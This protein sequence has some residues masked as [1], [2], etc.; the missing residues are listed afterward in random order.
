MVCVW[1]EGMASAIPAPDE[2]GAHLHSPEIESVA[3]ERKASGDRH[4]V[5]AFD[6]DLREFD[7]A[8]L[9]HRLHVERA[10][11]VLMLQNG[12]K[13]KAVQLKDGH[14]DSVK[15]NLLE[16][17]LGHML[18]RQGAITEDQMRK[19]IAQA[20]KQGGLQGEILIAM[21][22]IDE[23]RLAEALRAQAI[24][25]LYEIFTWKRGRFAF[26][27][28]KRIKGGNTLA[29]DYSVANM[30]LAGCRD[31]VPG[32]RIAEFF[33][34]YGDVSMGRASNEFER[35]QDVTVSQAEEKVICE[36]ANGVLVSAYA[37]AAEPIRRAVYGLVATGL[38]DTMGEPAPPPRARAAEDDD[39]LSDTMPE[40]VAPAPPAADVDA[41]AK[42]IAAWLDGARDGTHYE[43][44]D[45][46]STAGDEGI[47]EAYE[48][49]ARR[50]HRDRFHG[51]SAAVQ[52]IADQAAAL[53]ARA[54][55][56]VATADKRLA[57]AQEAKREAEED[58]DR[59][60]TKRLLKAEAAFQR[61]ETA[62]RTR[63]YEAALG[64]FGAAVEAYPEE[65][66]Y[67][68]HYG[69]ALH[70][71][72]PDNFEMA[73]EAM[74][75]VQRGVKLARDREKPYLFLGRLCKAVGR[76]DAAEKMF[77]K[78]VQVRPECVE[79]LRELRLINMRRE[80][81]KGLF[82]RLLGR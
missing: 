52:K 32:R 22:W 7:F 35:F 37:A 17:C 48:S 2:N 26:K 34:R 10:T 60:E 18:V 44:L 70:L 11:G 51:A 21:E 41:E 12:K 6:G 54:Y 79:A 14:P 72:H 58:K 57:Y 27:P 20:R 47:R 67:H 80:K 28:G 16:E 45:V 50:F 81:G 77:T 71:C 5:A 33:A 31:Y 39:S 78:A 23:E 19:S 55:E 56:A 46:T 66:E 75:H 61:G 30:I 8:M 13:K 40:G 69:W 15:S 49:L 73:R 42:E 63:D 9:L 4:A 65:G 62:L 74:E 25:K 43:V 29:L 53:A 59:A 68:A 24:E 1:G 76:L 82:G 38:V 36:V 3:K 64:H